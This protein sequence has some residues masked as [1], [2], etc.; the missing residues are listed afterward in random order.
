MRR[1]GPRFLANQVLGLP[2]KTD[3]AHSGGELR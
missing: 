1:T 3:V 2:M